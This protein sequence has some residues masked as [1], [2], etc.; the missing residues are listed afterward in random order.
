MKDKRIIRIKD[1]RLRNIRNGLRMLLIRA[2]SA[3]ERRF[4]NEMNQIGSNDEGDPIPM[5]ELEPLQLKRFREL[6]QL[7]NESD[8]TV[9]RSICMCRH[10]GK[11]DQDMYYNYPYRSWYCV[12]CVDFLRG[13]YAKMQAKKAR[14]E[15]TCDP[16]DE[17]G[18]SF[19]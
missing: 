13:A 19:Y 5:G 2:S 8:D 7:E 1:S 9:R 17:F 11:P 4:H 10:C 15:Y 16:D 12:E 14:G 3:E 18:Q 6:Q